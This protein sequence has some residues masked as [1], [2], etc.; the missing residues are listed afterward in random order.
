MRFRFA[1][2]LMPAVTW[3]SFSLA[4]DSATVTACETLIAARRID[5]AA[6][7]G[8]PAASEAEC[9]RIP[10]S[11]VGTVEQRAMIGGAPYECMTVAGGGRCRWIVP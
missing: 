9:R 7:S 8:Q 6:G 1:L 5:A 10:R 2:A 4:Q 11:Q 3:A